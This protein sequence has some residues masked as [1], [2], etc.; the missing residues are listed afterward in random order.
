MKTNHEKAINIELVGE[1]KDKKK[2]LEAL[3]ERKGDALQKPD[4]EWMGCSKIKLA[5][6]YVQIWEYTP[7][8]M[9]LIRMP[10]NVKEAS[11]VVIILT[12]GED[13]ENVYVPPPAIAYNHLEHQKALGVGIPAANVIDAI[14]SKINLDDIKNAISTSLKEVINA[15]NKEK[16]NQE[17]SQLVCTRLNGFFMGHSKDAVLKAALEPKREVSIPKMDS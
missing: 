6:S 5:S 10:E 13:F 12:E 9:E 3:E 7:G 17:I 11:Y 14:A 16:L 8:T 1:A 15:K 4:V 2:F